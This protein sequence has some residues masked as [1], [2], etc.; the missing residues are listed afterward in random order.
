MIDTEQWAWEPWHDTDYS[1]W[2]RWTLDEARDFLRETFEPAKSLGWALSL[3]GSTIIDGQGR[4][5]DVVATPIASNAANLWEIWE[6]DMCCLASLDFPTGVRSRIFVFNSRLLDVVF[7][8][9]R[10]LPPSPRTVT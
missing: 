1:V 7:F 5:L 4:D 8:P 6:A 3:C 9:L 2:V 10:P